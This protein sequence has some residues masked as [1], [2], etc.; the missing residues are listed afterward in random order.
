MKY[1]RGDLCSDLLISSSYRK[2][3]SSFPKTSKFYAIPVARKRK[4]AILSRPQCK[5]GK[6]ERHLRRNEQQSSGI[7]LW[8]F[9]SP[10]YAGLRGEGRLPKD[11]ELVIQSEDVSTGCIT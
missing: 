10:V 8:S 5:I 2:K 3:T 7:P 6:L 4:E 9:D 11:P 1:P